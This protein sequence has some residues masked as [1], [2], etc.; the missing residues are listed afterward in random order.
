M[1]RQ[2]AIKKSPV[3]RGEL[4]S[5]SEAAEY[6]HLSRETVRKMVKSK[7][8]KYRQITP[9]KILIDSADLDDLLNN[10]CFNVLIP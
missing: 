4:L 7:A 1:K 5:I 6:I 2:V 10:V 8:I 3:I 9:G